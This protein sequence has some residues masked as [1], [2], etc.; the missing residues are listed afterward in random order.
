MLSQTRRLFSA[1][2]GL[3][4]TALNALHKAAGGE[5]VP[6][7][8]WEMPLKYEKPI[9]AS[10]NHCREHASLFDV[11]HMSQ[12]T[13]TG[14][15]RER[16]LESI[17]MADITNS[18]MRQTRLS[19]FTTPDGGIIDDLMVTRH[20]DNVF[21]VSNA[22]CREK[23][24][25]HL[26]ESLEASGMDVAMTDHTFDRQLL[27]LQGPDVA[28]IMQE[29]LDYDFTSQPFMSQFFGKLGGKYGVWVSRSGYTGLDGVEISMRRE[30]AEAVAN[31]LLRQPNV[32]LCGLG[33][34]DSLRL[35]G[36]LC[37]YGNEMSTR[38]TPVEAGLMWMV[39]QRRRKEGGFPGDHVIQEQ[40][41]SGVVRKRVG[42]VVDKGAPAREHAEVW[43]ATGAYRIGHVT[44]GL[45]S[46]TLRKPIGMA[47][48]NFPHHKVGSKVSVMVRGKLQP[49]T[50]V[51]MPFVQPE[52]GGFY[53]GGSFE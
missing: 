53:R 6:F 41:R 14:K 7:A 40:L 51:K 1:A 36:G 52:R 39:S 3:Q 26:H 38:T 12:L 37:L 43:D 34:R 13:F 23:D 24:L 5:M 17:T 47:Y 9:I 25:K 20:K 15:D 48:V 45:F 8:G 46:P 33:P 21:F 27:A 10:H 42:F 18:S 30:D 35:E 11:S 44:S 22:G 16:F 29:L 4:K 32:E 50:I 31:L 49:A 19:C 28:H 2:A